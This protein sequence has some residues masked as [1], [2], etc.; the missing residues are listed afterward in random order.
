M[1]TAC[2]LPGAVGT[3][4]G[5]VALASF[6]GAESLVVF[7]GDRVQATGSVEGQLAEPEGLVV[8]VEVDADAIKRLGDRRSDV[9]GGGTGTAGGV[10]WLPAFLQVSYLRMRSN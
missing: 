5:V 1:V 10:T 9:C 2:R 7:L 8:D 4:T 6:E 3:P